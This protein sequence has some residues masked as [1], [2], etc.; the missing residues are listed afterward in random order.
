MQLTDKLNFRWG[1]HAVGVGGRLDWLNY[2]SD[3]I[4][5]PHGTFT[6]S[7][8]ADYEAGRP[9]AFTQR[10]GDPSVRYSM[11]QAAWFIQDD[12]QLGKSLS[13]GVGLR[14]E[15]QSHL[16]EKWNLAPRFGFS[17][18]PS[19]TGRTTVRGA[20]GIFHEWYEGSTYEET[21]QVDGTRVQDLTARF[22][23]YPR[24]VRRG[25]LD[26]LPVG[27]VQQAPMLQMPTVRQGTMAIE[28][29]LGSAVRL[30]ASYTVEDA[31][32]MLRARNMNAPDVNGTRPEP[33]L[34]NVI[35][36]QSIGRERRHELA[37]GVSGRPWRRLFL[38]ARYARASGRDDGDG[39][40]ALPADHATPSEWA[41]SSDDIRHQLSGFGSLELRKNLQLGLNLRLES[42]PPYTITTGRDDNGDAEFNDRPPDVPRNSARGEGAF[43]LDMRLSWRIGAGQSGGAGRN[44]GG[45]GRS[46]HRIMTEFY[47]RA[48]NAL[49]SVNARGFSGVLSSPFFGRPTFAEPARRIEVGI[50]IAM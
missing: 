7:T 40:L 10:R 29:R 6:F 21:L 16:D 33:S 22:P 12:V 50:Q 38:T 48:L 31:I 14:H 23:A 1:S 49:N 28:R 27:R 46:S 41:P 34:G 9:I 26:L 13:V 43:R 35:E 24:S 42:A 11:M 3:E 19:E 36:I 4:R 37:A 47:I 45:D 2:R 18:A 39:P 8:L 15:W 5:N 32:D 17:W 25:K 30:N 20:V 44:A